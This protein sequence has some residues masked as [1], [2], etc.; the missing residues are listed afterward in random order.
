MLICNYCGHV[1]EEWETKKS[2]LFGDYWTPPEEIWECPNC[3]SEDID[4]AGCCDECG[5]WTNYYDM[6]DGLCPKCAS[7]SADE[8]TQ[9][10]A[11]RSLAQ[12]NYL[13]EEFLK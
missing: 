10:I 3:S 11:S 5:H 2:R 13:R 4:E 7:E 6:I 8:L 9:W 12:Q 1:F